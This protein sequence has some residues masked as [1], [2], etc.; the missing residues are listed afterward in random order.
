MSAFPAVIVS[1]TDDAQTVAYGEMTEADL[2]DGDVTVRVTHSTIRPVS[3]PTSRTVPA[4]TPSGR[5]VVSRITSTGL[6]RPGASSCTPPSPS[7]CSCVS[8]AA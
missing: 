5:S 4:V 7:P 1:K 3:V 2:M 8:S 6:P